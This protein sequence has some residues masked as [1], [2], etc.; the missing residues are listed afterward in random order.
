M[1]AVVV[2]V[3]GLLSAGVWDRIKGRDSVPADAM[4]IKI[5]AKQ[6][7]WHISYPGPDGQLNTGDDLSVRNQLHLPVNKPVV[8]DLTSEDAIHSFFIPAFRIKQDAVPGMTIRVWFQAT[9]TG[10]FELACAELCGLGHYR[11]RA[12]ATVHAEADYQRWLD[13][14]GRAA[15]EL[16]HRAP[17]TVEGHSWRRRQQSSAS[18]QSITRSLTTAPSFASTS[19]PPITRSSAFSSCSMSLFFLLIGGLL[20]MVIRWQLGFPGQPMPGGGLLPETMAPGGMMLPEFY[21]SLVTMHG[22]FMVFFAIMPLLVGVFGNYLIPLQIGAQ[23]MAFP[24]INMASFWLAVP[25]GLIMLA[26]FFV[27]GGARRRRLDRLRTAQR[28]PEYTGVSTGQVLWCVSLIDP[29]ALLDPGLGQLHHDDHQHARAGHDLV[30]HAAQRS[31]RC[32]SR[33][34]WC[35]SRCRSWSGALIM[36]LFDQTLGTHFFLPAQGGQPLLWQ[37]LFWFFGHPEVYILILPAMGMV[38]DI[39]ANGSRKPIF[40]YTSMVL[41]IIG[42][43]RSSAGSSGATT[44][45]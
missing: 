2:V 18:P 12:V 39:I 45:S 4:P 38:S 14:R 44:C 27:V 24:R 15:A 5:H 23:D 3:I 37:H 17:P 16:A 22:T 1:T 40:G 7:E 32:S 28:Q 11:M 34:S 13:E 10:T 31:G 26:S 6:F 29:R 43:R 42:D 25:A 9:D 41:A 30:P 36:L 21:N 35:C 20:A 33:R 8:A 19:S